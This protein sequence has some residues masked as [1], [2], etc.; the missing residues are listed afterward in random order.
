V[1]VDL[2]SPGGPA[3]PSIQVRMA[4]PDRPGRR[5]L[6]RLR[7]EHDLASSSQLETTLGSLDGSVVVDLGECAFVD[8]SILGILIRDSARRDGEGHR[9]TVVAPA[10]NGAVA[11]TLDVSGARTLL[12]VR[13]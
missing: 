5:S 11:R 1:D 2:T 7:G 10:R 12:H 4:S 6:V 13:A 9:L 8:S 3:V